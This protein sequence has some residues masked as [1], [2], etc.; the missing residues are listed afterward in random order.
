LLFRRSV[1]TAAIV[2]TILEA[3][4]YLAE[5]PS[6]TGAELALGAVSFILDIAGPV[7]VQGGLVE[8]VRNVHEGRRPKSI[9]HL[10]ESALRRVHS[11]VWGCLV[12]GVGIVIGLILLDVVAGH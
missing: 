8:I 9:E 12:Y 1:L 10:Y 4:D 11:L 3:L 6:D 2:F 5:I 7:L